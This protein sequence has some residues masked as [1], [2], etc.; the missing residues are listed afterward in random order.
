[1]QTE[2]IKIYSPADSDGLTRAARILQTGGLCAIPTETVYG[3][4]ANALDGGAVSRI[5]KAK[6][7]PSDNPLIVHI[8]DM[9]MLSEIAAD[10]PDSAYKLAEAYWPG[11]LTMVLPKGDKIPREVSAGLDTVAV[12]MPANPVAAAIIKQSGL[13]LAAP[14]ANLSGSPSPTTAD[15]VIADLDGRVEGIVVS[16]NCGVGVESTVVTLCTS[17]PRLLRPGAVTPEMLEAVVGKIEIDDAVL[18]RLKEGEA[19]ASP[20]M[21]YKHY[22][23][24]AQIYLIEADGD[25]YAEYVNL[26]CDRDSCALCFLEDVDKLHCKAFTYGGREDGE[27]QARELFD[28]LRRL[29]KEGIKTAYAHAPEKSGVGLAVYNRL[30]RAAAF[31]V[32]KL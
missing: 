7:R 27:E 11:P 25:R 13:P 10:V 20:G 28:A 17:P 24:A 26:H 22:A 31:R 30:V 9:E 14:S 32:I 23:P 8:A 4:A 1:M 16:D 29:D 21:K 19:A 18:N 2:L 6:G 15:H 12:R 3:L 5:F